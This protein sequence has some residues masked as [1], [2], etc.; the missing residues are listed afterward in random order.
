MK[1]RPVVSRD[2]E[3]VVRCHFPINHM[4]EL[5]AIWNDG[6]QS[7]L[8]TSQNIVRVFDHIKHESEGMKREFIRMLVKKML[9]PFIR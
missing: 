8:L 5:A 4:Q 3:T 9:P 7:S 1:V 6:N 2:D